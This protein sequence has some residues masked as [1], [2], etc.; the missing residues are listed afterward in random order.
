MTQFKVH[1]GTSKPRCPYIPSNMASGN[2]MIMIIKFKYSNEKRIE[3]L[4]YTISYTQEKDCRTTI[5]VLSE[6]KGILSK[7]LL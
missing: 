4:I 6:Q 5:L 2:Q 1:R 7:D 3:D